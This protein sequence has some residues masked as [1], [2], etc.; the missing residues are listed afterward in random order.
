MK[1]NDTLLAA[2]TD[3]VVK[4]L[5][6][7][8]SEIFTTF[9]DEQNRGFIYSK[10]VN[11]EY[12]I[13]LVTYDINEYPPELSS[14]AYMACLCVH[15]DIPYCDSTYNEEDCA[16]TISHAMCLVTDAERVDDDVSAVCL[17]KYLSKAHYKA[18]EAA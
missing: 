4:L 15:D 18:W 13:T 14:F 11:G 9:L 3:S 8:N 6:H 17:V 1:K 10:N 2:C 5:K 7:H 16:I 12:E